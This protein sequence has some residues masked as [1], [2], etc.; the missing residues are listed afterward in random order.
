MS[1][2]SLYPKHLLDS[3]ARDRVSYFVN[4]VI[5]DHPTLIAAI[6][7][8]DEFADPLLDRR[9][10]LLVGGSGVGK[11]ALL[12]KLVSR[13]MTRLFDAIRNN[14]QLVPAICVEMEPPDKGSFLFTSLY[15]DA[16]AEMNAPL[17]HRTLPM[18]D[19]HSCNSLTR[20]IAVEMAGHRLAPSALKRRFIENLIDRQVDLV[21][22][23]EAINIFKVGKARSEAERR[24]QLKDQ[25]DKL[26]TFINKTP[27]SLVLGGAYD[28]LELTLGSGQ[29]ARRTHIVH[30]PPYTMNGDG[31]TGF[32]Y[33][34]V[35]LIA[36]LPIA[37]KINPHDHAS[38]LFLQSL[39]CI[40]TLKNILSDAL[41]RAIKSG[42]ELT[43][44]IIRKCYF[45]AAQLDVMRTEMD[46]GIKSVNELMTMEQLAESADQTPAAPPPQS[47]KKGRKLAPGETRPSHRHD[48][49]SSWKE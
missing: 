47:P 10:I 34:L 27:T 32:A 35:G 22:L 36:H 12:R 39:G 17:I 42:T 11:T 45:T 2:E 5:V 9:L 6:N 48:A 46:I 44:D 49:T 25:S 13:R 37:H 7:S 30:M 15:K 8:V 31:L 1:I 33:A 16:L 43:M 29:L 18:V 38:E 28:F 4:E 3:P 26:K 40:G 41:L 21:C 24:A 23:D 19:R 20:T 14:P